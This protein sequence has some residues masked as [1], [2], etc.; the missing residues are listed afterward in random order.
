[1]KSEQCQM[2]DGCQM[3]RRLQTTLS[4]ITLRMSP[5]PHHP[6]FMETTSN[7]RHVRRRR[8]VTVIILRGRFLRRARASQVESRA[9]RKTATRMTIMHRPGSYTSCFPYRIRR[10]LCVCMARD[11][12]DMRSTALSCKAS[13]PELDA[14][15]KR[16]SECERRTGC[17][18][19]DCDRWPLRKRDPSC[20]KIGSGSYMHHTR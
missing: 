20:D 4:L 14:S 3:T 2:I 10:A 15:N 9:P 1:M 18:E 17:C 8:H 13:P 6:R 11:S 19:S 5:C 7:P 16:S 12:M